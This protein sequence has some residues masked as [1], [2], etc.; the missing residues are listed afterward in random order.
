[1]SIRLMTLV[2]VCDG[3]NGGVEMLL[4]IVFVMFD[5]RD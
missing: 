2:V 5:W 4:W 3:V 1:M